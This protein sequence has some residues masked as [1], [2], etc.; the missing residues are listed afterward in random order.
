MR[1]II[2]SLSLFAVVLVYIVLSP[3]DKP[4]TTTSQKTM[5]E[6]KAGNKG[7]TTSPRSA[8]QKAGEADWAAVHAIAAEYAP[9]LKELERKRAHI[10]TKGITPG[11]WD[12]PKVRDEYRAKRLAEDMADKAIRDLER[13][14]WA[15]M[16]EYLSTYEL[17][18]YKLEHSQLARDMRPE[19]E[20]FQ[21]SKGEFVALYTYHE[22]K[23]DLLDELFGGDGRLRSKAALSASDR[24]MAIQEEVTKTARTRKDLEEG[25]Q[26]MSALEGRGADYYKAEQDLYL[27]AKEWMGADRWSSFLYGPGDGQKTKALVD[28]VLREERLR[29]L[30]QVSADEVSLARYK[31]LLELWTKPQTTKPLEEMGD[32]DEKPETETLNELRIFVNGK[33]GIKT[34]VSHL[35]KFRNL[36]IGGIGMVLEFF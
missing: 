3:S 22:K 26:R 36:L 7:K 16:S 6:G 8:R 5:A 31:S 19:L 10:K 1:T 25:R 15:R 4:T 29:S 14:Q 17:R 35:E 33:D 32:E 20:W 18:E 2:V 11:S 23:A 24:R 9:Q 12:N 21:P 13:E 27:T 28:E 34:C 30:G